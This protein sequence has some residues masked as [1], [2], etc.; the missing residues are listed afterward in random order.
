MKNKAAYQRLWNTVITSAI[1][2]FLMQ[3]GVQDLASQVDRDKIAPFI[4]VWGRDGTQD[5][6]NCADYLGDAGEQLLNC[7]LPAD[8]LPLNS[9]GK[10]W[11]IFTDQLASPTLNDCLP[12][13][14][15]TLLGDN[16]AWQLSAQADS[17]TQYFGGTANNVT[18]VIWMDGRL[19]PAPGDVFQHGHAIGHFDG[20][21]LVVESTNYMFDPDGID[22][23]LHMASSARKKITERYHF[24]DEDTMRVTITLEDPIFLKRP[25]VY[26]HIHKRRP[27]QQVALWFECDAESSRGQVEAGYPGVKYKD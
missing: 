19:H 6:G 3:L 4:G 10:A 23:H 18:R 21:D 16:A 15:P 8:R 11:L 12:I 13:S 25:F 7:S 5:R 14:M 17:I 2:A 1:V 27:D 26:A 20:D 24:V 22:D 9:R